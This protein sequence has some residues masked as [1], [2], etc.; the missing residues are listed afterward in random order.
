MGSC[1]TAVVPAGCI[2]DLVGFADLA[3]VD[4]PLPSTSPA[5]A[6]YAVLAAPG[7]GLG[8]FSTA[9]IAAGTRILTEKPLFAVPEPRTNAAVVDAFSHLSSS[10]QAAYLTLHTRDPNAQGSAQVIDV[11]NTNAWQTG[12][13]TSILVLAARFN[14]SCIPNASFAWN[15]RLACI[16]VHAVV[17]IPANTQIYLCYE[18]PY[19]LLSARR[20]K[21]SSYGFVCSCPAC[22]S[23]AEA[24]E[25][26]RAR[27]IVLDGRIRTGRRRKWKTEA[28]K[29]ALELV[30]L[31]KEEGIF[32]EALGLAYHDAA[33]AWRRH[34]RLDMALRYA[35]RELEV[36]TMCYG[37]D[38]PFVDTT[39]MLVQDLERQIA[40]LLLIKLPTT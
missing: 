7:E 10:D 28:P 2:T 37:A 20:I 25:I 38:S 11:F 35:A 13:S 5:T 30:R 26:R 15:A 14:H 32:G 23:N 1:G 8:C 21:L 24:S 6:L 29:G 18:R 34:G 9:L 22:G 4:A 39:R 3:I 31:L 12:D 17:A 27:M 19:Q 40:D 33:A 16:T 36:C